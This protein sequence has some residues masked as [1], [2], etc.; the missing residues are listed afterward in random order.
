MRLD[1][2]GYSRKQYDPVLLRDT[3]RN[4]A[5]RLPGLMQETGATCV[6]VTGKSGMALAFAT[7]MLID[8]NLVVVRKRGE[9]AHGSPVEGRD[10]VHLHK[11]LILDDFVSSGRTVREIVALLT[12]R[13]LRSNS[14]AL[15]CVGVVEY[16]TEPHGSLGA[17]VGL[18]E[19]D[20]R[21]MPERR[22]PRFGIAPAGTYIE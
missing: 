10:G 11:Y 4:V 13:A 5:Q 17:T 1:S 3:A 15:E 14:A 6:A 21:R 12:E 22:V 9:N 20:D 2:G 7:L 16:L 19:W 18:D 8:F